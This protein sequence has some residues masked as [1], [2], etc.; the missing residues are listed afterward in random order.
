[1]LKG[2]LVSV[3]W[4]FFVSLYPCS[5]YAGEPLGPK[6]VIKELEFDYGEVKE[7]ETIEHTF[8]VLNQ[9]D[10]PLEIARVRPG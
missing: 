8:L 6:M 5:A 9:G 7:G 4:L 1:M 3:V 10:A 2:W